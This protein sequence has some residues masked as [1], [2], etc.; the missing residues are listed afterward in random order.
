MMVVLL[1][2]LMP[3]S[4]YSAT[5]DSRS[6]S[7]A[8]M[9]RAD[10]VLRDAYDRAR[11]DEAGIVVLSETADSARVLVDMMQIGL[12]G[13][14]YLFPHNLMSV[15]HMPIDAPILPRSALSGHESFIYYTKVPSA[16][17]A[18][19]SSL[20]TRQKNAIDRIANAD[21]DNDGL[22]DEDELFWCT[23]PINPNSD[24][25]GPNDGDEVAALRAWMQNDYAQNPG[26]GYPFAI[27]WFL[28]DANRCEDG[29]YD[30]IPD[31]AEQKIGL[32]FTRESTDGDK[33]DDGQELYGVTYFPGAR[34]GLLPRI[35]DAAVISANMP[36]WVGAPGHHPLIAAFPI[37]QI[38]IKPNSIN[39]QLVTTVTTENG[40]MVQEARSLASSVTEGVSQTH[41][42]TETWNTWEE[43]FR[44]TS[45]EKP[46]NSQTKK[47]SK[48]SKSSQMTWSISNRLNDTEM[49]A[50]GFPQ[51]S[52]YQEQLR[53]GP[54]EC[55]TPT[56]EIANTANMG[57]SSGEEYSTVNIYEESNEFNANVGVELKVLKAGVGGSNTVTTGTQ[58]GQTVSNSKTKDT[59]SSYSVTWQP[60]DQFMQDKCDQAQGI[61]RD[62]VF[63]DGFAGIARSINGVNQTLDTRLVQLANAFIAPRITTTQGSRKGSSYGG[64]RS[65]AQGVYQEN[66]ITT[67]ETFTTATDWRTAVA[68]NSAHAADLAFTFQ[69]LNDGTDVALKINNIKFNVYLNDD[70]NP[71]HTYTVAGEVANL[72]PGN[73]VEFTTTPKIPLSLNELRDLDVNPTCVTNRILE[74]SDIP[75]SGGKIRIEVAAYSFDNDQLYYAD[76]T[77]AGISIFVQDGIMDGDDTYDLY[78]IA[79]KNRNNVNDNQ[80]LADLFKLYFRGK[81][82]A[83]GLLET[84]YTP[85]YVQ[86]NPSWCKNPYRTAIRLVWCEHRLST[87]ESWSIYTSGIPTSEF[88]IDTAIVKP[89]SQAIIA[90]SADTDGDG[91]SDD[92]EK[93]LGTNPNYADDY[94]KSE[95]V[96]GMVQQ[97]T[98]NIVESNVSLLNS[99]LSDAYQ[100]EA[101]LL[102]PDD[103]I[104]IIDG[105]IGG[106]G[107]VRRLSGIHLGKSSLFNVIA[108]EW[109]AEGHALPRSTSVYSGTVDSLYTFTVSCANANGCIVGSSNWALN[110]S[111]TTGHSGTIPFDNTYKSPTVINVRD[112]INIGM[113][114]GIVK[115]NET[116]EIQGKVAI[117]NFSYEVN[118]DTYTAPEVMVTYMDIHGV[119]RFFMPNTTKNIT[120][121]LGDLIDHKSSMLQFYEMELFPMGGLSSSNQIRYNIVLPEGIRFAGAQLQVDVFNMAEDVSFTQISSVNLNPGPNMGVLTW[122]TS[123]INSVMTTPDKVKVV[124]TLKDRNGIFMDAR[125]ITYADHAAPVFAEATISDTVLALGSAIQGIAQ[126]GQLTLHNAGSGVLFAFA[127]PDDVVTLL[128]TNEIA[129][130]AGQPLDVTFMVDTEKLPL[131]NY[132]RDITLKTSDPDNS[133]ITVRI[134]GTVTARSGDTVAYI[135][136]PYKPF[137]TEVYVK[138]PKAQLAGVTYTEP[139]RTDTGALHP[140]AVFDDLTDA[141]VGRGRIVA[142]TWE[143]L[144]PQGRSVADAP[145]A[146]V[147]SEQI[148]SATQVGRSA[149]TSGLFGTGRDGDYSISA[150]ATYPQQYY[151]PAGSFAAGTRVIGLNSLNGLAVGDEVLIVQMKAGNDVSIAGRYEFGFIESLNAGT[152]QITLTNGTTNGYLHGSEGAVV[153]VL[154]VNH[155]RNVT[156]NQI[157]YVPAW[158]GT[159][160]GLMAFRVSGTLSGSG[161]IEGTGAGYRGGQGGN[162]DIG[163]RSQG[164]FGESYSNWSSQTV[165]AAR[166]FS[167]GGGAVGDNKSNCGASTC[168][169]GGGGGAANVSNGGAGATGIGGMG[170]GQEG[171]HRGNW[172]SSA[173]PVNRVVMGSGGGGGGSDE[174]VS[175]GAGGGGGAGVY[176]SA[177][178]LQIGLI[179]VNGSNG[180]NSIVAD[181]NRHGG[182]GGGAGGWVYVLAGIIARLDAVNA[183]GGAGGLGNNSGGNGG[184]GGYGDILVQYCTSTVSIGGTTKSVQQIACNG[185]ING[186]VY[187]DLNQNNQQD[188]GEDGVAGV[189]V[190]IGSQTTTTDASGVYTFADLTPASYTVVLTLPAQYSESTPLSQ[191]VTVVAGSTTTQNYAIIPF[192]SITGSVY[193]DADA[194][195]VKDAGEAGVAGVV[196][197]AAGLQGTSQADGSYRIDGVPSGEVVVTVAQSN[198]YAVSSAASVTVTVAPAGS[199]TAD[200][201]VLNYTAEQ[202]NSSGRRIFVPSAITTSERY[203]VRNGLSLTFSGANQVQTTYIDLPNSEYLT[204]TMELLSVDT[205][206]GNVRVDIGADGSNE[207]IPSMS[208]PGRVSRVTLATAINSYMAGKSGSSVAVPVRITSPAAGT[209]VIYNVVAVPKPTV[210]ITLSNM[211]VGTTRSNARSGATIPVNSMHYVRGTVRNT[212]TTPSTPFSVAAIAD[213]T[214]FGEWYLGSVLV[215]ALAVNQTY[216]VSI[217]MSTASWES[218]TGT[219][220]LIVDPYNGLS[221]SLESNN[222]TSMAFE[223]TD[224]TS[225]V[226]PTSTTAATSTRTA[227][228]TATATSTRTASPTATATSTRTASPTS[229]ATSTRTTTRTA[230]PTRTRTATLSST[231]T[232]TPTVTAVR[233]KVPGSFAKTGP[234]SNATGQPVTVNLTWR[235]SSGATSYEYCIAQSAPACTKW[236][237]AGTRLSVTVRGLQRNKV[238]YWQVRAKNNAG[239]TLSSGGLW[240][241]TTV[242]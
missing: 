100:I 58:N 133:T 199:A 5:V 68:V 183:N 175:A 230:T 43:T 215:P 200:F 168:G 233:A 13:S 118:R 26:N 177:N 74:G 216:T 166:N 145:R 191:T 174:G 12:L 17:R 135:P 4:S 88:S 53:M 1:A 67:G 193:L 203:L 110:W 190:T 85:E 114:G 33:F 14:W 81:T 54:K 219:V 140:V 117:D 126:R 47:K 209:I 66:Q 138:G 39:V 134:T 116:F 89:G 104:T 32:D 202:V 155:F 123:I 59:G 189:T 16:Q 56:Y 112:G 23:N 113:W 55:Y 106:S 154:K 234:R 144:F 82:D 212:G 129:I 226:T 70:V 217:P 172:L 50:V 127:E 151:S 152:T 240:W 91:I 83:N 130:N 38:S 45:I 73:K 141:T 149:S 76:A 105:D 44:Q 65:V 8:G 24:G 204:V 210:D 178:T 201:G 51:D 192:S 99:G 7:Y 75:C 60:L 167:A 132:T 188:A 69:I 162:Y 146:Q 41:T 205:V 180:Q 46:Y 195:G 6:V 236:V 35:E 139:S 90:I 97:R 170:G 84:F 220:K 124:V 37:P 187:R 197:S 239:T 228:P 95:L 185:N 223:V 30:S 181:K 21:Q 28:N 131:G 196:L 27:S 101:H 241:F 3:A 62:A 208:A 161:Y 2:G 221:E 108:D 158:N 160:G 125:A 36:T 80:T 153:Q 231:R 169:G 171:A 86:S 93:Y 92:M 229:T 11:L 194:D 29:D 40:V 164:Y 63:R 119:K 107:R 9:F 222:E 242:R 150:A 57:E 206:S 165:G 31:R 34:W 111:N 78:T 143:R 48:S 147:S 136:D 18:W 64:E 211:S 156:L 214:D 71:I 237:S 148:S 25:L 137:E 102:A 19:A 235:A 186:T 115:N 103:S 184:T 20:S 15:Q 22:T 198:G 159:H 213:V 176:I 79:T 120:R 238:Y 218:V 157:L 232:R 72:F 42:E 163:P 179:Q 94:P 225:T 182:G 121:S 10:I 207:W 98:G 49:L 96:A 77:G 52:E 87:V 227:S 142:N 224:G 61:D 122:S 173:S 109:F 128:P